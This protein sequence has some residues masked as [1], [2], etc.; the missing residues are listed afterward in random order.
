MPDGNTIKPTLNTI[1]AELSALF[2]RLDDAAVA[3]LAE[4][5]LSSNAIFVAGAGRSGMLL[6]CFTMRLMHMGR[7][8]YMVGEVVTPAIRPGDLLFIASGSG[9]TASLAGMARKAKGIGAGLAL[10]TA[11]PDSTITGLADTV[12]HLAAPTPKAA[13]LSGF[14]ASLQPMGNLFEQGMFLLLE[15]LVM[16]LMARTGKTS[17]E[18]FKLH[19]NLE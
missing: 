18:M 15:A 5:M 1:L 17:E 13:K 14:V 3:G 7:A 10:V 2:E 6:R 4:S 12:V 9:E 8:A 11:N 16:E 19:A